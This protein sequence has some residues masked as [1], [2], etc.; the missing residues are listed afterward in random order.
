MVEVAVVVAAAETAPAVNVAVAVAVAAAAA[1]A[2]AAVA[3]AAIESFAS[4]HSR[5]SHT[6]QIALVEGAVVR[7][8]AQMATED[9]TPVVL[10]AG[11]LLL[12]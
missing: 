11:S 10:E 3:V 7:A 8:R 4:H 9:Y 2:A 12:L 5:N 6:E 1:A